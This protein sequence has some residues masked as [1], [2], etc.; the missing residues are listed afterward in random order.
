M[1]AERIVN[2][3]EKVDSDTG[4]AKRTIANCVSILPQID[5]DQDMPL[6]R[7]CERSAVAVIKQVMENPQLLL[8]MPRLSLTSDEKIFFHQDV[9]FPQLVDESSEE[10]QRFLK[11]I[12]LNTLNQISE[13]TF[14]KYSFRGL[15]DFH[16]RMMSYFSSMFAEKTFSL[17][18][19][20]LALR[21]EVVS[22][23]FVDTATTRAINIMG[24]S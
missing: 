12:G 8:D 9:D 7:E 4:F 3:I 10:V 17:G 21:C 14:S 20:L 15:I 22:Q 11:S 23:Q 6:V 13:S 2:I 24:L 1:D 5:S 19:L 16:P 18:F